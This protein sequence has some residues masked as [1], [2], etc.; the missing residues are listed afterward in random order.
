MNIKIFNTLNRRI[1]KFISLKNKKISIYTC[2]PT[3]YQYAHI[4]NLRTYIFIDILKRTFLSL[5]FKI[6][7][8]LN[9]TDVG[10]LEFNETNSNLYN[11]K[12]NVTANLLRS[13]PWNIAKFYEKSFFQDCG[14]LNILKPDV[15]CRATD[16]I[17]I[18]QNMIKVIIKNKK[19]YK[20]N[21]NIYFD[22]SKINNYYGLSKND[23]DNN[24]NKV[25]DIYKKN[26][27]DFVLW[28][29]NSKFNNQIMQW[30]SPWGKGFP[31][32]HIECSAMASKYLG[33]K[34]DI[35]TGGIDH[36]PIHH[37]NEIAQSES[38][39]DNNWVNYWV[40]NNFLKMN[41]FKMSKSKNNYLTLTDLL[42][43]GFDSIDY[44]YFCL[45]THYRSDILFNW[46]YLNIAKKSM[47]RLRMKVSKYDFNIKLDRNY[48]D[49]LFQKNKYVKDIKDSIYNDFNIPKVLEIFW[50]LI[51][52]S[53][54]SDLDKIYI[55]K[56]INF[57]L[58][59]NLNIETKHELTLEQYELI[60]KRKKARLDK[61]W[62][63]S[64]KIRHILLKQGI[65]LEDLQ[66]DTKW[67]FF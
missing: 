47:E 19:A 40:H 17:N 6:K 23:K 44:K 58:S 9:I 33:K 55:I 14:N 15:I 37:S 22:I 8:V 66:N 53:M 60:N 41:K 54:T 48:R 28:F 57:I 5:G 45:N 1:E 36:I 56:F 42:Y 2:G 49:K 13:S 7:H 25:Y 64:D 4:G 10:H 27:N 20:C 31:G 29:S 63:L 32:W 11:D 30:N 46:K 38:F 50:K 12:I 35:H 43:N 34:I 51:K 62:N 18:M 67:H 21:N 61:D 65:I 16:H 59:L 52:D 26:L 3:V 39:W 24:K